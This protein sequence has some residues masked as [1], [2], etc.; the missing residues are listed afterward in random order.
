MEVPA[1]SRIGA[2]AGL[3]RCGRVPSH[4]RAPADQAPSL[5]TLLC[6]KATERSASASTTREGGNADRTGR[7]GGVRGEERKRRR[8]EFKLI[9]EAASLCRL[10]FSTPN[11]TT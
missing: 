11:T 4:G 9:R 2:K 10:A 5:I 6:A 8:G 1:A 3:V 7:R